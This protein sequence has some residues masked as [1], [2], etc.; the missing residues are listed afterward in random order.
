MSRPPGPSPGPGRL[1]PGTSATPVPAPLLDR[2]LGQLGTLIPVSP[3]PEYVAT[4]VPPSSTA[5]E[6]SLLRSLRFR[7]LASDFTRSLL[8]LPHTTFP[9][10]IHTS[11]RYSAPAPGVVLAGPIAVQIVEIVDVGATAA[12]QAARLEPELHPAGSVGRGRDVIR[13]VEPGAEEGTGPAPP[14]PPTRTAPAAV[15]S[16]ESTGPHKLLLEDAAGRRVWAFELVKIPGIG[17]GGKMKLG[18]K[19]S[20]ILYYFPL[21]FSIYVPNQDSVPPPFVVNAPHVSVTKSY[22]S[23]I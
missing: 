10:D 22:I 6:A 12:A 17:I 19:V 11:P 7:L 23:I 4:L 13:T 2:L 15:A 21:L 18:T 16:T 8:A 3:S 1:G 9:T 14:P 5:N 20:F